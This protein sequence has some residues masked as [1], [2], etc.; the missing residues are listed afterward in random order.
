MAHLSTGHLRPIYDSVLGAVTLRLR[1]GKLWRID[2]LQGN[3]LKYTFLTR[4]SVSFTSRP[5]VSQPV[6]LGIKHP[7]GAYDQICITSRQLRVCWC[8]ASLW[9]EDGT[10]VYNC[11]W[12]SPAQSFSGPSRVKLATIF[13]CLKFETPLSVA[14]HNSQGCGGGIRPRLLFVF[15]TMS[16]AD[17]WRSCYMCTPLK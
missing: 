15:I 10:L 12:P 14:S 4:Q 3:D 13:Y 1:I 5:T 17:F 2:P 16:I 11:C 9:R 8:V 7:S 6:Y